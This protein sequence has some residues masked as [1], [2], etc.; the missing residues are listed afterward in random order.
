VADFGLATG[1]QTLAWYAFRSMAGSPARFHRRSNS[2]GRGSPCNDAAN[3]LFG[4]GGT[5]RHGSTRHIRG[6]LIFVGPA[7]V[8]ITADQN[9]DE[10]GCRPS[11]ERVP[12][13]P[14]E[15][16]ARRASFEFASFF[17]QLWLAFHPKTPPER[18]N[19]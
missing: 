5:K 13:V 2:L 7:Y 19:R 8:L 17:Q 16:S 14:I 11:S 10:L 9:A 1:D 3:R 18:N 12:K 15:P 4:A 6:A